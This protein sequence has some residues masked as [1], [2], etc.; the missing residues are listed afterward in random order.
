MMLAPG[1]RAKAAEQQQQQQHLRDP[2]CSSVPLVRGPA[3]RQENARPTGK[4]RPGSAHA[5]PGPLGVLLEEIYQAPGIT[6]T[7]V[8]G[9]PGPRTGMLMPWP[10]LSG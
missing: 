6:L 8:F 9:T 3:E 2:G 10:C 1:I 5:A 7:M 4:V